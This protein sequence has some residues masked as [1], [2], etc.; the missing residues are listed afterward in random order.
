MAS[1]TTGYREKLLSLREEEANFVRSQEARPIGVPQ[2]THKG[3][4]GRS[5]TEE[6]GSCQGQSPAF[7]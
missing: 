5:Q 3:E 2:S 6:R 4:G 7:L 1:R